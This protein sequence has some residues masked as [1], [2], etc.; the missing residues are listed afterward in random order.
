MVTGSTAQSKAITLERGTWKFRARY[1]NSAT[2]RAS[3]LLARGDGQDQLSVTAVIQPC[4]G[5]AALTG[6]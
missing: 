4:N 5:P 6:V 1:R 2:G 3:G